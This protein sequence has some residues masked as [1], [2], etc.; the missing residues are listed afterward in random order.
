MIQLRNYQRDC[1]SAIF[2]S[3]DDG[4]KNVAAILPTGCLTGDTIIN[5]NRGGKGGKI[6]LENLYKNHNGTGDPKF[7]KD[8]VTRVRSYKHDKDIIG[9]HEVID[10]VESGLKK[11]GLLTLENGSTIKATQCHKFL[12]KGNVWVPLSGLS[13]A[14]EVMIDT[15]L[16]VKSDSKK[17]KR[18]DR[19]VQG[20]K[21]HPN[22]REVNTNSREGVINR[23]EMYRLV[24]EAKINNIPYERF[25]YIIRNEAEEASKLKYVDPSVYDI[26]HVDEDWGNN[27]PENLI[28]LTK[29]DHRKLHSKDRYLKF[30]QGKP[31]YSRVVSIEY[32][33]VEMTYDI[34]CDDPYHNFVANGMVV[35]NSGKTTIFGSLIKNYLERNP[36]KKVI[37][38][39]HLGLLVEQTGGRFQEEWGM[40]TGILQA[41][42]RPKQGD[43]VVITTMQSARDM[44]KIVDWARGDSFFSTNIDR[45]NVGM[46][47]VDE[48][49]RMGSESYNSILSYFP[50][51]KVVGF[52]ATPF[53][54]NKLMTNIFE[55]V[56]YTISMQELIDDGY[57][58][59][60]ELKLCPFDP[61]DLAYT[62]T[63]ISHLYR[64]NHEGEKAV[65]YMKSI[66]DAENA[67]NVFI[68]MGLTCSAI[69]S[70]LTGKG[71][72]DIL[73]AFRKGEGPDILTTVDVLTAGFDSPNLK[74]IF[75]PYKVNSVTTYL[76][77]V[78]RGL[79]P[80]ENKDKC[81]IYCGS[82]S[83]GITSGFW[84]E[85][86]NKMLS[87]GRRAEDCD[88]LL[89]ILELAEN[90]ISKEKFNWT[91]EVVAMANRCKQMGMENIH[92]MI[93]N[94]EIPSELMDVF[95][96]N[97]PIIQGGKTAASPAQKKY[98]EALGLP[99]NVTKR[100]ANNLITAKK[101]LDGWVPQ[102]WETVQTGKHK[103]KLFQE[104]PHAYWGTLVRK[105]PGSS[106]LREYTEWKNTIK[107]RRG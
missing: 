39:S 41:G 26:H 9:L 20:I 15:P 32:V 38:V 92:S 11:V 19:Q 66:E 14:F 58:V 7:R 36:H 60:P 101:R 102:K 61:T 25:L 99:T 97:P 78:G 56:V 107:N 54:E 23:L 48:M 1:E 72:S 40:K 73:S 30:G 79:R 6:T 42:T 69:T 37:V 59:K 95:V 76:Q 28:A 90:D 96:K 16:P 75:M 8:I 17:K 86:T 93:I 63:M 53:R 83:P 82:K 100:E 84:E 46:I 18:W 62:I 74:A 106:T 34:C 47:V 85:M 27:D 13:P 94:Q 103:G 5:I 104:V 67:R 45:L 64:A 31:S 22:A 43:Q 65:I 35:H 98:L 24:Y 77:R 50:D 49:H 68:E 91:Q 80:Y 3:F 21:Y 70:K 10:V 57:L 71:R 52:T 4:H 12:T 81:M 87:Q 89:E 88:T 44:N 2:K 33:G 105:F 51:A 55:K 29:E